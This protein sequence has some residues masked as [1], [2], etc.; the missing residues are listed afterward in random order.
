MTDKNTFVGHVWKPPGGNTYYRLLLRLFGKYVK[1]RRREMGKTNDE[2]KFT[3]KCKFVYL[4]TSLLWQQ[5][6]LV[7]I[8]INLIS[9]TQHWKSVKNLYFTPK[10]SPDGVCGEG[11]GGY[12]WLEVNK[13]EVRDFFFNF[14]MR[15]WEVSVRAL[16]NWNFS[17][18]L[19]KKK[20]DFRSDHFKKFVFYP[21]MPTRYLTGGGGEVWD[22]IRLKIWAT[23]FPG[24]LLPV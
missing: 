19:N 11:G 10:C 18:T 7:F 21:Q 3:D 24:P 12:F 22:L 2:L 8:M 15:R 1:S 13:S 4:I 6:D 23:Q 17:R 14:S 16:L 20:L 9:D 5:I